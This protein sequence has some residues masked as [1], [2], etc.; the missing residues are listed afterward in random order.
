MN[1]S[2][3]M[4]RRNLWAPQAAS[5]I[6]VAAGLAVNAAAAAGCG[7]NNN[8]CPTVAPRPATAAAR[9]EARPAMFNMQTRPPAAARLSMPT[10]LPASTHA[11]ATRVATN[12]HPLTERAATLPAAPHSGVH[13]PMPHF[14]VRG[15]P[16]QPA[17]PVVFEFYRPAAPFTRGVSFRPLSSGGGRGPAFFGVA[18]AVPVNVDAMS[19]VQYDSIVIASG[20]DVRQAYVADVGSP[21]D[22]V[23]VVAFNVGSSRPVIDRNAND[24]MMIKSTGAVVVPAGSQAVA[25]AHL[26]L[27]P[28]G[29]DQPR[30]GNKALALAPDG[31]QFENQFSIPLSSDSPQGDYK[32]TVQVVVNQQVM[33]E[34]SGVFQ[35]L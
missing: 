8:P 12:P 23:Q 25:N 10:A 1:E 21:P 31:G 30:E 35:A 9:P 33:G 24:F 2:S 19:L 27:Y 29:E 28:P 26:L 34:Q 5:L 18:V 13:R 11:V 16:G 20:N 3:M 15:A 22:T 6:I 7:G 17:A 4:E 14:V 32:Y